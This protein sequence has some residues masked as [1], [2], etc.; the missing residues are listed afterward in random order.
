M[1]SFSILPRLIR[2]LEVASKTEKNSSADPAANEAIESFS[3]V[4]TKHTAKRQRE[5]PTLHLES[6]NRSK[7]SSFRPNEPHSDSLFTSNLVIVATI[8]HGPSQ[9]NREEPSQQQ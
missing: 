3:K 8:N 7:R 5:E 9:H 6:N 1:A 2:H 4:E